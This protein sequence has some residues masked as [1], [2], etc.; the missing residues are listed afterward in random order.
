MALPRQIV[1]AL[2][3]GVTRRH[4][5]TRRPRMSSAVLDPAPASSNRAAAMRI[6]RLRPLVLLLWLPGCHTWARRDLATGP[7]PSGAVRGR[8]R[9]TRAD[10][11]V[12]DL[13]RARVERDTLRGELYAAPPGRGPSAVAVPLDSV[14]RL[15]ARRFSVRRTAAL[16]GVL[17]GTWLLLLLAFLSAAGPG[18]S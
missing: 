12:L 2:A 9:A 14:R 7:A 13:V 3:A 5:G 10:G 15:D 18:L 17:V 16:G 11:R 8:V 6:A 4:I 1:V